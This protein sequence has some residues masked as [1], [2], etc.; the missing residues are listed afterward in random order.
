MALLSYSLCLATLVVSPHFHAGFE[1]F[2]NQRAN[3]PAELIA[4]YIDLVMRGGSRAVGA[5]N[6][7][8]VETALDRALVLFRYIQVR[9]GCMVWSGSCGLGRGTWSDMP[10]WLSG[11][12]VPC[13]YLAMPGRRAMLAAT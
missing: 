6:D 5:V 7:D 10:P 8:E 2:I 12:S 11:S 3:K 13:A 9:E 1:Y 4:K